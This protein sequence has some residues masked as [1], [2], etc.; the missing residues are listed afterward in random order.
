MGIILRTDVARELRTLVSRAEDMMF[1]AFEYAGEKAVERI[2]ATKTYQDRTKRLSSS[3][4]YGVFRNGRLVSTGGFGSGEGREKGLQTLSEQAS[5]VPNGLVIVAG[6][7]YALYV[8][9]K[10]YIVLDGGTL[11]IGK[12]IEAYLN[13]KSL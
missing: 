3:I 13:G 10:G 4:G 5:S 12:D 2:M 6:M 11:G 7:E 1:D 8:E 9:R